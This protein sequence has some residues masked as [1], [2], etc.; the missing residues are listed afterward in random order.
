L[1]TS[2]WQLKVALWVLSTEIQHTSSAGQS[3]ASLQ[4]IQA[5]LHIALLLWQ[6]SPPLPSQQALPDATE[7]VESP[8]GTSPGVQVGPP[9]GGSHIPPSSPSPQ[10]RDDEEA[11][12][13]DDVL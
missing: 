13:L 7:Q 9:V 12:L 10:S 4:P 5:P 2:A 11:L 1:S 8:H 3:A 6:T